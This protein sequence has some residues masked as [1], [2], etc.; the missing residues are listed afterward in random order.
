ME[1]IEKGIIPEER[2]VFAKCHNCKTKFSFLEGEGKKHSD[3]REGTWFEIG[4]PLCFKRV[5]AYPCPIR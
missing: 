3:Q 4:C 1:I 5:I 2:T